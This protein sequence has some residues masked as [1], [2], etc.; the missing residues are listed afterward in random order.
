MPVSNRKKVKET[1][2]TLQKYIESFK[3]FQADYPYCRIDQILKPMGGH[4]FRL[5]DERLLMVIPQ[6]NRVTSILR[7]RFLSFEMKQ[8]PSC[9]ENHNT[10]W[11]ARRLRD[12]VINTI[13]GMR[14]NVAAVKI[15]PS[16]KQR[17][18]Q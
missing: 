3:R 9:R 5:L 17:L 7:T 6:I 4:S 13:K 1:R 8:Y 14:S 12:S 10:A 18:E 15:L 2:E 11:E 16:L